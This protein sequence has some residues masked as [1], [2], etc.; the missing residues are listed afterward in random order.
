V[1]WLVAEAG[2]HT[3]GGKKFVFG[4]RANVAASSWTTIEFSGF[5]SGA[6]PTILSQIQ[7]A[8][9]ANYYVSTR[10]KEADHDSFQVYTQSVN[11]ASGRARGDETIGYCIVESGS[12]R[13]ADKLGWVAGITADVHTHEERQI[14]LGL[15]FTNDNYGLFGKQ[16]T[17]DG[18]DPAALRYTTKGTDKSTVYVQEESCADSEVE[19]TTE[20]IA[21]FAIETGIVERLLVPTQVADDQW[22]HLAYSSGRASGEAV[23]LDGVVVSKFHGLASTEWHRGMDFV[24][25]SSDSVR[26]DGINAFYTGDMD[27]LLIFSKELGAVEVRALRGNASGA[28]ATDLSLADGPRANCTETEMVADDEVG[29]RALTRIW[30]AMATPCRSAQPWKDGNEIGP[31][32]GLLRVAPLRTTEVVAATLRDCKMLCLNS[33]DAHGRPCAAIE[34]IASGCTLVWDCGATRVADGTVR[35]ANGSAISRHG[36]GVVTSQEYED[37]GKKTIP[38][39]CHAEKSRNRVCR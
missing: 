26:I 38:P 24:I 13:T 22:H 39:H 36:A 16:H 25:G 37:Q 23:Y 5:S 1:A 6:K 32:H 31:L 2:T 9:A 20:K 12:G 10:H 3:I 33:T 14:S 29:D 30:V 34:F 8:D 28:P 27:E 19:H 17:M 35:V 7:D 4:K 21:Y 15:T 11:S 18:P